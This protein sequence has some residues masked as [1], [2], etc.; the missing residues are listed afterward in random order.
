MSHAL[1]LTTLTVREAPG[2]PDAFSIDTLS[3]GVVLVHGPNGVGKST[4][5]RIIQRLLW[6]DAKQHLRSRASATFTVDGVLHS[7]YRDREDL[8][9]RRDGTPVSSLDLPPWSD[10]DRY[11]LSLHD[12]IVPANGTDAFARHIASLSQGGFQFDKAAATIGVREKPRTGSSA[13]TETDRYRQARKDRRTAE[14]VQRAASAS[15]A[16]LGQL[17]KQLED[18]EVAQRQLD[19]LHRAVAR[20]NAAVQLEAARADLA[21]FPDGMDLVQD[22]ALES[23]ARIRRER[24]DTLNAITADEQVLLAAG[25]AALAAFA[26]APPADDVREQLRLLVGKWEQAERDASTA[27]GELAKAKAAV[28][29]RRDAIGEAIDESALARVVGDALPQLEQFTVDEAAWRA[30]RDAANEEVVRLT[31][32]RD[33]FEATVRSAVDPALLQSGMLLLA[34]WLREG[35]APAPP[36]SA[37]ASGVAQSP[38]S[39]ALLRG[40]LVLLAILG[41]VASIVLGMQQHP[42]WYAAALLALVCAAIGFSRTGTPAA[43]PA[44]PDPRPARRAEFEALRLTVTPSE[45]TDAAVAT[46]VERIAQ[47]MADALTQSQLQSRTRERITDQLRVATHRAEALAARADEFTQR[48]AA[49]LGALGIT[50]DWSLARLTW[51]GERVREW[52]EAR[53]EQAKREATS[54]QAAQRLQGLDTQTREALRQAG[55]IADADALALDASRL[56]AA[57]SDLDRRCRTH[58]D[59]RERERQARTRLE[60]LQVTL[61]RRNDEL[62]ELFERNGCSDGDVA[63]LE[64]RCGQYSAYASARAREADARIKFAERDDDL[65]AAAA[66]DPSLVDDDLPTLVRRREEAEA[67]AAVT[68]SLRGRCEELRRIV[69]NAAESHD[70]EKALADEETTTQA[71]AD[72]YLRDVHDLVGHAL[73]REVQQATRDAERPAVFTRAQEL[74][75]SFTSARYRLDLLDE[76]S[77]PTFTAYDRQ[78]HISHPLDELSTGT[79]VQLLLAVRLAFVETLEGSLRPPLLMDE[80]LGTSDPIRAQAIMDAVAALARSGRQVFYFTAQD[81]EHARWR[82]HLSEC[83]VPFSEVNLAHVRRLSNGSASV[84][85]SE[86]FAQ[87]NVPSPDGLSHVDY[88]ARLGVPPLLPGGGTAEGTHVWYLAPDAQIVRECL[89]RGITH[90]GPLRECPESLLGPVA[91]HRPRMAVFA[92]AIRALHEESRVGRGKPV[93]PDCLRESGAVSDSFMARAISLAEECGGDGTTILSKLRDGALPRFRSEFIE[94]L[95]EYFRTAGHIVDE[96]P[97]A[98]LLVQAAV[99]SAFLRSGL[100]EA[101]ADKA[102]ET[103]RVRIDAMST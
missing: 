44:P 72:R 94:R 90:W 59:A 89:Q 2:L 36:A 95:E 84:T 4:T 64:A 7:A 96:A 42:A 29:T 6:A 60:V 24:Q 76:G 65:R 91:S 46:T 62:R 5:A 35:A 13:P 23:L 69:R 19:A 71:L 66:M 18:A 101:E 80:V 34:R 39:P 58:A 37:A 100:T 16:E 92:E 47:A 25:E 74:F 55:R 93:T 21:G 31:Q 17:E 63:T 70:L 48:R 77:S 20:A 14:E 3:T 82:R 79:K 54:T 43:A 81:D 73:V 49:L 78:T 33:A 15:R 32:E 10:H 68:G 88:G 103:L 45:W 51:L 50:G 52:I 8:V 30:L 75:E 27:A 9:L 12:L 87:I 85:H 83:D 57:Y 56:S 98:P 86:I 53:A 26:E 22:D 102:M 28:R 61:A 40:V 11:L 41:A 67:N 99:R 97:R 1:T 38:P